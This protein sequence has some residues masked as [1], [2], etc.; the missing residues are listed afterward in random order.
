M[1]AI[2]Q[3]KLKKLIINNY[4]VIGLPL[5]LTVSIVIGTIALS[6]ILFY[7]LNPCIF[8][9]KMIVSV[10]PLI[11]K[12]PS[13]FDEYNFEISVQVK[14][15][16]GYPVKNANVLVK[17]LGDICS[18]TTNNKGIATIEIK[19]S[20]QKGVTEGYLDIIVKAQC[21]ETF[22]QNKMIKVVRSN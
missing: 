2:E 21:L 19:P 1:N 17:G 8:P 16:E 11:N 7:I 4:A 9:G 14:D 20:L 12:L 10:N 18:N 3:K 13:G 15:R 5:R 22:L 6:F